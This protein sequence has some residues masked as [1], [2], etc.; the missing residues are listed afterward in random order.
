MLASLLII[1][2]LGVLALIPQDSEK[3][4]RMKQIVL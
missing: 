1:P 4:T 2:I 3:E